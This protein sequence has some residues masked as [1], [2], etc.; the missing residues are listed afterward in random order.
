MDMNWHPTA[1]DSRKMLSAERNYEMHDVEFFAIVE[2]F[3]TWRYY[4]EG[5]AHTILFFTD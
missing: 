3:K 5:S 4:L 1:Y 2:D